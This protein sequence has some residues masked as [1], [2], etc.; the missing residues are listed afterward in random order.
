MTL[1][2]VTRSAA[3][4]VVTLAAGDPL[5]ALAPPLGPAERKARAKEPIGHLWN[6]SFGGRTRRVFVRVPDAAHVIAGERV[7]VIFNFHPLNDNAAHHARLTGMAAVGT[8]HGYITVH[9]DGARGPLGIRRWDGLSA[10]TEASSKDDVGFVRTLLAGLPTFVAS[11]PEM[12]ARPTH[13]DLD[14]IFLTGFSIGGALTH[15]LARLMPE[16]AAIAPVGALAARPM[17]QL[18]RPLPTLILHSATDV[19]AP[20]GGRTGRFLPAP[21]LDQ[22]IAELRQNNGL[23]HPARIATGAGALAVKTWGEDPKN[24]LRLVTDNYGHAWPG[25][26]EVMG[27]AT[28]SALRTILSYDATRTIV[29]FFEAV[30]TANGHVSPSRGRTP[31]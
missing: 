14:R 13:I 23:E 19:L 16:V 17:D 26:N 3:S 18:G 2:S 20:I 28:P 25:A 1:R 31:V 7:P 22:T 5:P 9:A 11:L 30:R 15:R 27:I 24:V 12:A 4:P 21:A 10:S 6:V 8:A 29:D